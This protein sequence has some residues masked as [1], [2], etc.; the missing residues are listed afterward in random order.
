MKKLFLFFLI[1]MI[2]SSCLQKETLKVW[3]KE[4][5]P[6]KAWGGFPFKIENHLGPWFKVKESIDELN[7]QLGFRAFVLVPKLTY[8]KNVFKIRPSP[9]YKYGQKGFCKNLNGTFIPRIKIIYICTEDLKDQWKIR[10]KAKEK[11]YKNKYFKT[12]H[13][14]NKFNGEGGMGSIM[15]EILHIIIQTHLPLSSCSL[16][17]EDPNHRILSV[18]EIRIAGSLR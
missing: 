12:I 10:K 14:M 15:H 6:V 13:L 18:E 5:H 9:Y 16:M 2:C 4:T 11:Q 17:C 8:F 3:T 1:F 7:K